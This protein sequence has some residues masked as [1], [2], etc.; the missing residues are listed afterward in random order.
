MRSIGYLDPKIAYLGRFMQPD[1]G[2]TSAWQGSQIR[3][4]VKN[5]TQVV[6]DF[7]VVDPTSAYPTFISVHIDNSQNGALY[8]LTTANETGTLERSATV[9]M[10]DLDEHLI[11]FKM[12]ATLPL[13]QYGRTSSIKFKAIQLDDAGTL[14]PY[15]QP[16][17]LTLCIGD[18]WMGG[19]NDWPRLMG[20]EFGIYPLAYGG[21]RCSDLDERYAYQANGVLM[22]GDAGIQACIISFGVNDLLSG[23][24]RDQFKASLLSLID[25]VQSNH[26][27]IPVFLVQIPRNLSTG[28]Q[29][30]QYGSHMLL[31]AQERSNV[32]YLE[33]MSAAGLFTWIDNYHLDGPGKAAFAQFVAQSMLTTYYGA[34]NYELR[35]FANGEI[36]RFPLVNKGAENGRYVAVTNGYGVSYA[37]LVE[38]NDNRAGPLL[39][40]TDSGIKAVKTV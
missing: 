5:S 35:A 2:M 1:G 39:V 15:T 22:Y 17:I 9:P 19:E 12:S 16:G 7:E 26:P 25:Q 24:T 36:Y 8:Y 4:K 31:A 14:E 34:F 11:T 40:S 23:I 10:P 3:M 29:F 32:F 30:D 18:S 27:D 28:Q 20:D 38:L 6:L 21:A 13:N 37:D 33:S